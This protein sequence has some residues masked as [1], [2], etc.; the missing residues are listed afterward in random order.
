M[1]KT[2]IQKGYIEGNDHYQDTKLLLSLYRKVNA[3]LIK[4]VNCTQ[5]YFEDEYGCAVT[6]FLTVMK[7]YGLNLNDDVELVERVDDIK[8]LSDILSIVDSNIKY[9]EE[10]Y[11]NG[12]VLAACLYNTYITKHKLI[13]FEIRDNITKVK[14]PDRLNPISERSY[15]RYLKEAIAALDYWLWYDDKDKEKIE[16]FLRNEAVRLQLI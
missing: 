9:I 8:Y 2:Y 14:E 3:I 16:D 11:D 5:R 12:K 4:K 6:E 1:S 15:H 13:N 10:S 7:R